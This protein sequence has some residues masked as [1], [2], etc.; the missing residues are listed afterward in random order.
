MKITLKAA[1]IY[2]ETLIMAGCPISEALFELIQNRK[3][4]KPSELHYLS[5]MGYEVEIVGNTHPLAQELS[6]KDI[7][8]VRNDGKI[9]YD[10]KSEV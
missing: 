9:T 4:L 6:K 5:K 8:Y 2:G 3:T 1:H 10:P 7:G